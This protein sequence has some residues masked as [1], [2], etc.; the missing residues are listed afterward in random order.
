M[1]SKK[2]FLISLSA[3]KKFVG[4]EYFEV[5]KNESSGFNYIKDNNGNTYKCQ[6]DINLELPYIFYIDEGA[7]ISEAKLIHAYRYQSPFENFQNFNF[8]NKFY[9]DTGSIFQINLNIQ[10]SSIKGSKEIIDALSEY[11]SLKSVKEKDNFLLHFGRSITEFKIN[12]FFT[13][14]KGELKQ[15]IKDL[16]LQR[17]SFDF[18]H[19]YTTNTNWFYFDY[20]KVIFEGLSLREII[21]KYANEITKSNFRSIY[22]VAMF[23]LDALG[24]LLEAKESREE[25]ERERAEHDA[26]I[27]EIRND[28]MDGNSDAYWNID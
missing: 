2:Y 15:A 26:W 5:V 20:D 17:G 1:D 18:I 19:W 21:L 6:D 4:A 14:R 8:S 24:V 9:D 23:K 13:P 16:L 3:F 22:K 12:S 7:D 10:P 25:F 28:W 27:R 11:E